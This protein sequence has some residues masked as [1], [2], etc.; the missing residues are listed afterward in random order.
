MYYFIELGK[1]ISRIVHKTTRPLLFEF[2]MTEKWEKKSNAKTNIFK[3]C[4]TS[5]DQY[6]K[7]VW[8]YADHS[9]FPKARVSSAT[10]ELA[11]RVYP[12]RELL[13]MDYCLTAYAI[14]SLDLNSNVTR[15]VHVERD[16]VMIRLT[17]IKV[18]D[19]KTTPTPTRTRAHT[20]PALCAVR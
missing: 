2:L 5:F 16:R 7:S 12:C 15:C 1:I 20:G 8:S 13:A 17:D 4:K 9:C 6:K 18:M 3:K 14:D 10:T 19:S 11:K